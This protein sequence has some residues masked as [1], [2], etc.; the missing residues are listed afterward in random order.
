MAPE[1]HR[2]VP[3]RGGT[4]GLSPPHLESHQAH[5][6]PAGAAAVRPGRAGRDDMIEPALAGAADAVSRINRPDHPPAIA[7]ARR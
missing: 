3:H 4:G 5:R 1:S 2:V 6:K 7:A